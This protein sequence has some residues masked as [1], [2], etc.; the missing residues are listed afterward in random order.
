MMLVD[1]GV[2]ELRPLIGS[3]VAARGGWLVRSEVTRHATL[4]DIE[5]V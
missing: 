2:A 1:T 3:R 4:K 5:A